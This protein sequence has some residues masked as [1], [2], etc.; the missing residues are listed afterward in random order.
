MKIMKTCYGK[1]H[2]FSG[3]MIA[4]KRIIFNINKNNLIKDDFIQIQTLQ[5]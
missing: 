5:V 3:W 4:A 2:Y 1:A